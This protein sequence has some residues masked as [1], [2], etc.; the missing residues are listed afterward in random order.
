MATEFLEKLFFLAHPHIEPKDTNRDFTHEQRL[1]IYRRDGG[2]CQLKIKCD[3]KRLAWD[4]WH[5]DH[6]V[7]HV[8][9]GKTTVA[10][11]QLAC[12]SCN[13]SKGGRAA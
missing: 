4:N 3:G 7:A 10:N 2:R 12:V 1:A 5:A 8:N 13:L 11:G 6:K 9:G